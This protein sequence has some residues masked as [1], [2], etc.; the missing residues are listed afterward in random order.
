MVVRQAV[1]A[2]LQHGSFIPDS[3]GTRIYYLLYYTHVEPLF[4]FTSMLMSFFFLSSFPSKILGYT[5]ASRGITT[6]SLF[7]SW[8]DKAFLKLDII[9]TRE[10]H[11]SHIV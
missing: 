9:P 10:E 2:S 3:I 8:Q 4:M 6:D 1:N 7:R 5:R 11:A